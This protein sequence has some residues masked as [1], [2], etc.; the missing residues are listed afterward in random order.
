M[1]PAQLR[2]RTVILLPPFTHSS[3]LAPP[4]SPP[5]TSI[6]HWPYGPDRTFGFLLFAWYLRS[7]PYVCFL[8]FTWYL[9]SRKHDAASLNPQQGTL[10]DN[11]AL[12]LNISSQTLC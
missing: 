2:G 4:T 3:H 8:L 1:K 10:L 9:S 7:R 12:I 5:G 6:V 11:P